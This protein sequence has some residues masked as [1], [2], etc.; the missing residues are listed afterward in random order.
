MK[1]DYVVG[2][3][4][5]AGLGLMIICAIWVGR[6][7]LRIQDALSR[8]STS[9]FV[10]RDVQASYWSDG[11]ASFT[12]QLHSPSAAGIPPISL[13]PPPQIAYRIQPGSVIIGRWLSQYEEF[14]PD[15]EATIECQKA[16]RS[17]YRS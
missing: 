3:I 6:R 16:D 8:S 9:R 11:G 17:G 5:H 14:F 1:S 13:E 4:I 2:V 15:W 12:V 7:K 10:V